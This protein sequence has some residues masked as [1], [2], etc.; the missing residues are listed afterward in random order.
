M[1]QREIQPEILDSL[2]PDHPDALHNR[3]DLRLTNRLMGNYRWFTRNLT[4]QILNHDRVLDLGA[5]T[6]ELG[7]TLGA[8]DIAVDGLDLWPRPQLWPKGNLWHRSDLLEF[9]G[10]S[11]YRVV[12]GNLIFHQFHSG[13]LAQLGSKLT[14]SARIIMA[15]EPARRRMSQVFFAGVGPLLGVNHVSLHDARVSIAA[16]FCGDELPQLLQLSP[17]EWEWR[18]HSTTFGAYRMIALR[19]Q[20]HESSSST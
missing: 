1:M 20:V 3:R 18:C 12:I 19:R 8:R 7:L 16:G 5:G 4:P 10:Y 6:G 11:D 17:V 15:S 14:R 9:D 13:Q 2:P